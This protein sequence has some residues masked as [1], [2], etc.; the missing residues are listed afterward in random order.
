MSNQG[1]M[2][3]LGYNSKAAVAIL[4]PRDT[5]IPSEAETSYPC[6]SLEPEQVSAMGLENASVGDRYSVSIEVEVVQVGGYE[7]PKAGQ[8]P[9]VRI[10]LK[11]SSLAEQID[12]EEEG[13]GESE[14]EGGYAGEEAEGEVAPKSKMPKMPKISKRPSPSEAGM[15]M[16]EEPDYEEEK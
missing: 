8:A 3:D 7:K 2:Q 14:M 15:V 11:K 13:S 12:G 1:K 6:I 4:G 10:D 5:D 16:E 9:M